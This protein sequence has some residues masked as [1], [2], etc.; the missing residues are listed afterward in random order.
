MSPM[1]LPTSS[2]KGRN[3]R[4]ALTMVALVGVAGLHW[5]S[6]LLVGTASDTPL[7][8]RQLAHL[9]NGS[10]HTDTSTGHWCSSNIVADASQAQEPG[11]SILYLLG[12]LYCF[13]FLHIICEDYFVETVKK[14]VE[15]LDI[16]ESAAGATIMAAGTSSPELFA[17]LF[18]YAFQGGAEDAG[19]GTIVG[20]L[21][22]NM[23]IIVAASIWASPN[24]SIGIDPFV[25]L[26]DSTF[27]AIS[28]LAVLIAFAVGESGVWGSLTFLLL[29]TLYVFI[30]LK[31]TGLEFRLRIIFP[32]LGDA[33]PDSVK[34]RAA[35]SQLS[36]FNETGE[37][38]LAAE[39]GGL[40]SGRP[41]STEATNT[42]SVALESSSK[43]GDDE[44]TKITPASLIL[45]MHYISMPAEKLLH[46][47]I[48]RFSKLGVLY[49]GNW[50]LA[51]Q[52][53]V[54]LLWLSAIIFFMIEWG[55]KAGCLLGIKPSLMGLTFL[56]VG[57]SLPDALS[58]IFVARS[59][60][61]AMAISNVFGSN[62][63]DILIALGLSWFLSSLNPEGTVKFQ[64]PEQEIGTIIILLCIFV[65]QLFDLIFINKMELTKRSAVIYFFGYCGFLIYCIVADV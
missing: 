65:L 1:P 61:G 47:T 4:L 56:A 54:C 42:E 27:Y 11:F 39:L 3:I 30:N 38:N 24:Q 51:G 62:I 50:W 36:E 43:S 18:G 57:T 22:F 9:R 29:Y 44:L 55:S 8:S 17:G 12:V 7:A 41:K 40:D 31:W 53:C 49:R 60:S 15:I 64:H 59:G 23:L 2:P 37:I 21:V 58:S 19:V 14:S 52:M 28:I 13:I 46:Y 34:T 6:R 35:Q 48:P 20:S 45:C 26:R 32:R 63:F 33:A 16:P 5:A 10:T 25:L